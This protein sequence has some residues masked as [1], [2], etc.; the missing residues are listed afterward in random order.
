MFGGALL[1]GH[2]N[3]PNL[4]L[5]YL[6]AVLRADG[7]DV[8]VLDVQD[9]VDAIRA[10]VREAGPSVVGLSVIF[11]YDAGRLRE[12]AE[13]LRRDG[14]AGHIT[15]GGHYPS[16]ADE[17]FLDSAPAIDSVIRFEGEETLRELVRRLGNGQGWQ[18]IEGI[19]YRGPDGRVVANPARPLIADLDT[20]PPPDRP[21]P[22]HRILGKPT[23][24]LLGEP[25]LRSRLLVLLDPRVLRLRPGA[26]VRR[27]RPEAVVAE[28]RTLF[29]ERGARIFLFQDDDF[30][31]YGTRRRALGPCLCRRPARGPT[32]PGGPSGRSAAAWTRW[33]RTDSR[34]CARPGSISSTWASSPAPR[35][36]STSS[37]SGSIPVSRSG[38]RA[39][40]RSSALPGNTGS[41]CSIRRRPSTWWATTSR[42]SAGWSPM[43]GERSRSAGC[44]PT[45]GRRSGAGSPTRVACGG[46]WPRRTTPSSTRRVDRLYGRVVRLV[47]PW[48]G[49]GKLCTEVDWAWQEVHVLRRLFPPLDGL[50]GYADRL[51]SI[52]RAANDGV[53]EIVERELDAVRRGVPS[54]ASGE[55][56]GAEAA[57]IGADL[58][59]ERDAFILR[60]Q[61]VLLRHL[62]EPAIATGA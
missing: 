47:D 25:R 15:A 50:D 58:R 52:T 5:G 60:H 46:A 18:A 49:N 35:S 19:T 40:W 55:W 51:R 62:G 11:Q 4:G 59:A 54:S 33:R 37:R 1:I 56:T 17:A 34:R 36:A 53:L 28:M 12:V 8:R 3:Q 32:C 14:Y 31:V 21:G 41:C 29:D 7:V 16:L 39:S 23:V 2:Q 30:P 27:R 6:S 10:A 9:G 43:V 45:R 22:L 44:C 24:P 42:T 61:P 38:R 20:L 48:L 13:A 26:P 57:R